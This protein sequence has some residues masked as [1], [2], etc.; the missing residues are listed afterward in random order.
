M[1]RIIS[2][3]YV[4][5]NLTPAT[6]YYY[7]VTVDNSEYKGTFYSAPDEEVD[8]LKFLVYGD[9]RTYPENHDKVQSRS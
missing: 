1:V 7:R 5:Q 8:S 6:K 9:N 3:L 2:I 4:F